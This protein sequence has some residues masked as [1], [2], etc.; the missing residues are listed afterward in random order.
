VGKFFTAEEAASEL[1][2]RRAEWL[3]QNPTQQESCP[4]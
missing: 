4:R 3:R 2:A 1:A